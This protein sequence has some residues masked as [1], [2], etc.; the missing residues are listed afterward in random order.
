MLN[1][2][3]HRQGRKEL[4]ECSES[5]RNPSRDELYEE[6]RFTRTSKY[7]PLAANAL[8]HQS[9]LNYFVSRRKAYKGIGWT[10]TNG[11]RIPFPLVG[12]SQR[13]TAPDGDRRVRRRAGTGRTFFHST[14]PLSDFSTSC[15][16]NSAGKC[17]DSPERPPPDKRI[18]N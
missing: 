9:A 11:H 3:L 5:K 10:V 14:G 1:F 18:S 12:R 2:T 7:M 17:G 6:K 13:C 4:C 16:D 8:C 15:A